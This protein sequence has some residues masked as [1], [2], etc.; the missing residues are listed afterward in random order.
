MLTTST[1]TLLPTQ[2]PRNY[3]I[4]YKVQLWVS[5]LAI[6]II[7]RDGLLCIYEGM[8]PSSI[9]ITLYRYIF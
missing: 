6:E 8:A 4:N 7:P 9:S 1:S 5:Q 2:I 3:H